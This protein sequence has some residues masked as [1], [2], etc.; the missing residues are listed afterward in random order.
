MGSARKFPI[1]V[2]LLVGL[3]WSVV[4]QGENGQFE[5]GLLYSADAKRGIVVIDDLALRVPK[6]ARILDLRGGYTKMLDLESLQKLARTQPPVLFRVAAS[7]SGL[8]LVEL[9]VV[10]QGG[11]HG[12]P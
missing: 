10:R 4:A 5:S 1:V 2:P 3:F 8:S 11:A 9:R 7:P 6:D 12:R